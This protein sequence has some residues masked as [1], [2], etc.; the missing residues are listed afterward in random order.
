MR[1]LNPGLRIEGIAQT[2]LPQIIF[3]GFLSVFELFFGGLGS[4][5]SNSWYPGNKL[6][7]SW[8]FRGVMDPVFDRW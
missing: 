8:I 2:N 7:N 4:S 6:E 5:F 3:Y 1:L